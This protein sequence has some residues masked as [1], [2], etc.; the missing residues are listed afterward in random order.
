MPSFAVQVFM[1]FSWQ[2]VLAFLCIEDNIYIHG[3]NNSFLRL[4]PVDCVYFVLN[5][6]FTDEVNLGIYWRKLDMWFFFF[7]FFNWL[8][9]FLGAWL[10]IYDIFKIM[11]SKFAFVFGFVRVFNCTVVG[12]CWSVNRQHFITYTTAAIDSHHCYAEMKTQVLVE[13]RP[14]FS[15]AFIEW[16]VD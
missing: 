1:L 15:M 10:I 12:R 9:A 13:L 16:G 4:S 2:I 6:F 3:F 14:L 8:L 5:K 11:D 7:S